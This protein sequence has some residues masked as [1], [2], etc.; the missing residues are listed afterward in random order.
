MH[1]SMMDGSWTMPSLNSGL[2]IQTDLLTGFVK[3]V[4]RSVDTDWILDCV[5]DSLETEWYRLP[6]SADQVDAARTLKD[7]VEKFVVAFSLLFCVNCNLRRSSEETPLMLHT[8]LWS[9][10]TTPPERIIES[11]WNCPFQSYLAGLAMR[12]D[13]P[14]L[15]TFHELL[16]SMSRLVYIMRAI[17]FCEAMQD[18]MFFEVY[19]CICYVYLKWNRWNLMAI[20]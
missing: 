16:T 20:L 10:L 18:D 3:A 17:I 11:V 1:E 19:V 12:S 7:H 13:G 5:G 6:L 8:L 14:V 2:F 15:R 9:L 4:L